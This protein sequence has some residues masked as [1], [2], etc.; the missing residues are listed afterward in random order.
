MAEPRIT[1][2]GVVLPS[3]VRTIGPPP[4][5]TT[6]PPR[7]EY[8]PN[9][10]PPVGTVG[11]D[12]DPGFGAT[13]VLTSGGEL[14]VMPWAGWP[15]EWQTP[16]TRGDLSRDLDIVFACIDKNAR[17][18]ADMPFYVTDA[19]GERVSERPSWLEN[20]QPEIYSSWIEFFKQAWV[21]YQ[22]AGE[23]FVVCTSRFADGKPRTFM[24]LH[25]SVVA[26]S[27]DIA[28]GLRRYYLGAAEIPS[29]DLLHIRYQTSPMN[30]RGIGPL[31]F[32]GAKIHAAQ[33]LSKYGADLAANGGVP[34]AV[35]QH[36]YRLGPGQAQA[37][38]LQWIQAAR[39]RMGAPAV[40]D[41]DTTLKEL[42]VNPKDMSLVELLHASEARLCIL[43]GVDP[44]LMGLPSGGD[45]LTYKTDAGI[46]KDHWLATLKPM[47]GFI[48]R[49]ISNWA[50]P[51]LTDLQINP[52]RYIEETPLL[53]A[54]GYQ[55]MVNMGAMSVDE[56]RAAESWAPA[57][58]ETPAKPVLPAAPPDPKEPVNV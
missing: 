34:W 58:T 29:E 36:K 8:L 15:S 14:A 35:L 28:T 48:T 52:D 2:G 9:D 49:A 25:P 20:P 11:V 46:R 17:I 22:A 32:A 13:H 10:N 3:S 33:V 19:K 38:K 31:E 27:I 44:H 41:S 5:P 53:R 47:G 6:V 40:L 37:M 18:A 57:K 45:S 21:S 39:S 26:P 43:M 16:T 51:H 56:V 1:F 23:V 42:N 4:D 24:V 55:I 12:T 30:G 50:L 7:S 54:Q